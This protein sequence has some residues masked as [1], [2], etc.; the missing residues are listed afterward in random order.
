M[1]KNRWNSYL[2][3][4]VEMGR[5]IALSLGLGLT[6]QQPGDPQATPPPQAPADAAAL[7]AAAAQQAVHTLVPHAGGPAALPLPLPSPRRRRSGDGWATPASEGRERQRRSLEHRGGSAGS[8]SGA[9]TTSSAGR[10]APS[11]R[12]ART[13][14]SSR[15]T[16]SRGGGGQARGS[17]SALQGQSREVPNPV[18]RADSLVS[19]A[20]QPPAA[21]AATASAAIFP[22]PATPG[23]AA[24]GLPAE[25]VW[26]AHSHTVVAPQ[27]LQAG[28]HSA[29]AASTIVSSLPA[30]VHQQQAGAALQAAPSLPS[31]LL[32]EQMAAQATAAQT[33]AYTNMLGATV[34]HVSIPAGLAA[35]AAL[36]YAPPDS[37]HSIQQS[38]QAPA[39]QPPVATAQAALFPLGAVAAQLGMP[40]D[41]ASGLGAFMA[42]APPPQHRHSAPGTAAPQALTPPAAAAAAAA[43][44]TPTPAA[45][46][47][48]P[49]S[50]NQQRLATLRNFF[51]RHL[52]P[53]QATIA[54][55]AALALFNQS[56]G[57]ATPAAAGAAA[58]AAAGAGAAPTQADCPQQPPPTAAAAAAPSQALH[59]LG[60]SAAAAAAGGLT[61]AARHG[62]AAVDM[63]GGDHEPGS[64]GDGLCLSELL[65][66][67]PIRQ[68]EE[69]HI[70]TWQHQPD[71]AHA[72]ATDVRRPAAANTEAA[73]GHQHAN[74]H[75][76]P[77]LAA[78][79]GF[80]LV[81]SQAMAGGS[82]RG[83][84]SAPMD[85][86]PAGAAA[87]RALAPGRGRA[88]L[89]AGEHEHV[90]FRAPGSQGG[91]PPS[92]RA[93]FPGLGELPGSYDDLMMWDGLGPGAGSLLLG[94]RP[95]STGS[96]EGLAA[97]AGAWPPQQ[98]SPMATAT[99]NGSGGGGGGGFLTGAVPPGGWHAQFAA[100]GHGPGAAAHAE[101]RSLPRAGLMH[102]VYG[103]QGHQGH[104]GHGHDD[105]V[106]GMLG[107]AHGPGGV[108]GMPTP[109]ELSPLTGSMSDLAA[110]AEA[111]GHLEHLVLG[112]SAGGGLSGARMSL[113]DW[114][115]GGSVQPAPGHVKSEEKEGAG[116]L[117]V[118]GNGSAGVA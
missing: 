29:P 110:A 101:G 40:H 104:H 18:L 106:F 84:H 87:A 111:D 34:Q 51:A 80:G 48:V 90:A 82:P 30:A 53:D 4:R 94:S 21:G 70:L 2:K 61:E 115:V 71:P 74:P 11:A 75:H 73:A 43:P 58:E 93:A 117:G 77:L 15:P 23:P 114:H 5:A 31:L 26:H 25:G 20:T 49:A 107:G 57:L 12:G 44:T 79:V 89:L 3:R 27:L 67:S 22:G 66:A 72:H 35:S 13:S 37:S 62:R 45:V 81:A 116:R 17:A 55:S 10:R 91:S 65:L 9:T 88:G 41:A 92:A 24:V 59:V 118:G 36:A 86:G 32:Q 108:F 46:S 96:G 8:G 1:V 103:Q 85:V 38:S 68:P 113:D 64:S 102:P 56:Q 54:A 7:H 97:L 78:A 28:F 63:G 83:R 42:P 98:A 95:G 52:P 47:I 16:S 76:D 39:H 14:S 112:S 50:V 100:M 33:T 109:S 99:A 19:N 6:P 60:H 69:S 105:D